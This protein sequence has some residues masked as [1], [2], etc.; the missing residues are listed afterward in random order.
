[1]SEINF[2]DK[3]KVEC[4]EVL[5][6]AGMSQIDFGTLFLSPKEERV[7]G[8][9]ENVLNDGKNILDNIDKYLSE[10]VIIAVNNALQFIIKDL[11]NTLLGY[12]K[13]T[14]NT[15]ITPE[16]PAKLGVQLAKSTVR[17]TAEYTKNPAVIL[18]EL[19][20]NSDQIL[21]DNQKQNEE[22]EKLKL[23]NKISEIYNTSIS[24]ITNVLNEIQPY[25][26]EIAKY[27]VYGPDYI[28][29]ELEALYIKYRDM[30][31]SIIN[32]EVGKLN[33]LIDSYIDYAGLIAGSSAAEKINKEQEKILKKS[34]NDKNKAIA[35]NKVKALSLINK[36]TLNLM[37][38][39][40]A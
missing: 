13:Q 33:T 17:Y 20:K 27:M 12:C 35:Q 37:A 36:A 25:S 38:M 26:S 32:T 30:G 22:N 5:K 40:G 1:M 8:Q 18:N 4:P 19:E 14:F 28:T 3:L 15:Y 29:T 39:L 11:T 21:E 7:I 23:L 6:Q 34:I 10:D 2:R 24:K 31:I 16:Y 9:T